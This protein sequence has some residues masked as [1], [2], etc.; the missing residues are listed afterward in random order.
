MRSF[1]VLENLAAD[2]HESNSEKVQVKSQ[3]HDKKWNQHARVNGRRIG[4]ENRGS[5][6]QGIPPVNRVVDDWKVYDLSL[7]HIDAADE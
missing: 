5:L 7:I 2:S 4:L 3:H 1:F 6:V